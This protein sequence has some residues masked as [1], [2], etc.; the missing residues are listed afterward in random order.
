ML[1]YCKVSVNPQL[2]TD[3][4]EPDQFAK[5]YLRGPAEFWANALRTDETEIKLYQNDEKSAVWNE[6]MFNTLWHIP[7][8]STAS[9][10]QFIVVSRC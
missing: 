5:K 2:A 6:V 1:K 9:S 10:V 4:V 8:G 3:T 7:N